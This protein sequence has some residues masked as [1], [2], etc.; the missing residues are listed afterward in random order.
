MF[1]TH[2]EALPSGAVVVAKS[3][4][5]TVIQLCETGKL[6]SM[7]NAAHAPRYAIR[8]SLIDGFA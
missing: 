8:A 1:P 3:T 6:N 2:T 5:D 4:G 7:P